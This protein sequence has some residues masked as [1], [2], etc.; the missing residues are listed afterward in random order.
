M[1]EFSDDLVDRILKAEVVYVSPLVRAMETCIIVLSTAAQRKGMTGKLFDKMRFVVTSHLREKLGSESDK[2]GANH[3]KVDV[4]EYLQKVVQ[5]QANRH[6]SGLAPDYKTLARKLADSYIDEQVNSEFFEE[7]PDDAEKFLDSITKFRAELEDAAE[8]RV[9]IIGHNGWA[10]WNFAA[11]LQGSCVVNPYS[12]IAFGGRQVGELKNL[13]VLTAKFSQRKFR[14]V[15]VLGAEGRC[16]KKSLKFGVF[17]SLAEAKDA[18]LIPKDAVVH[19]MFATKKM[20]HWGSKTRWMT[21]SASRGRSFLAW[22]SDMGE[23]K[24]YI[25]LRSY[26]LR[27]ACDESTRAVLIDNRRFDANANLPVWSENT[28]GNTTVYPFYFQ[29]RNQVDFKKLCLLVRVHVKFGADAHFLGTL[30]REIGWEHQVEMP[31]HGIDL[32]KR[33][34]EWVS[35]WKAAHPDIP[36]LPEAIGEELVS[37]HKSTGFLDLGSEIYISGDR[38][39]TQNIAKYLSMKG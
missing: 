2:P 32:S 38:E 12:H 23:P 19:H 11:G 17:A 39:R 27:Y 37:L 9:L 31:L 7:D 33:M 14:D 1:N 30:F 10:R 3:P 24:K 4:P 15:H 8:K 18:S 29:A 25:D 20:D 35:R 26:E 5:E 36:I 21:L 22:S 34:N 16:T 28:Q 6:E 13:G